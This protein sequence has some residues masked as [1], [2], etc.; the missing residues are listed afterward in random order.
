MTGVTNRFKLHRQAPLLTCITLLL[1]TASLFSAISHAG[2]RDLPVGD[3]HVTGYPAVGNVFSCQADFRGGGAQHDGPWFHGK[4]WNP[5]EKLLVAGRRTWP[6]AEFSLKAN[7]DRLSFKGNGLP[8]GH[9]TGQFPIS[10]D[11]PAY[12][13]DTNPNAIAA[14]NLSFDIPAAPVRANSPGCLP[15]GMIGFTTTGVAIYNALDAA[16]RDAA[17]HE[18]QDLCNGHPQGRGQYHYHSSSP[19]LPG[20]EANALVG[21]ALDGYPIMGMRDANGATLS[22]AGLDA[23]HGRAETIKVDGR[24]YGYAY[25]LTPEY[26]YTLGCFTG[27]SLPGVRQAIQSGLGPPRRGGPGGPPPPRP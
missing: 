22:N 12:R 16:G 13:Y 7:G 26:P 6:E 20:A 8:V 27:Q 10:P 14:G 18:V 3:G 25:R 23:C 9:P 24:S 1:A 4:T 19:C 11:D 21:W 5:A 2:A 15:M 17:A